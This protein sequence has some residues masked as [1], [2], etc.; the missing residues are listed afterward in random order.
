MRPSSRVLTLPKSTE[1]TT[2]EE[3]TVRAVFIAP[4]DVTPAQ[5]VWRS[6][7]T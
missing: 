1:Q 2:G 3:S 5:A 4:T 7:L 6:Q